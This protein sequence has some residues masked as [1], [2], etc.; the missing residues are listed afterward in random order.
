MDCELTKLKIIFLYRMM[1]NSRL[2][3]VLSLSGFHKYNFRDKCFNSIITLKKY[4]P[5]Y[6]PQILIIYQ[7]IQFS[8]AYK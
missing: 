8:H 3:K 5:Q 2:Y 7:V 6:V 1:Q 4:S